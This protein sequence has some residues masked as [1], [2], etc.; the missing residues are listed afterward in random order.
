MA[1][2]K[3]VWNIQ[4]VRDKQL[5]SLWD[6][7]ATDPYNLF[8]W[9]INTEG[10]LGLN[11]PTGTAYSSPV[12]LPGT[13][14]RVFATGQSS[15]G[16]FL[17]GDVGTL[18]SFG[19]NNNGQLGLNDV[20]YRSSP[21]QIPGTTWNKAGG[22]ENVKF[23]G[24]TDGTLWTWGSNTYGSLGINNRTFHSSPVQIPGT[25]WTGDVEVGTSC[26]AIKTDGTL[27]VWGRNWRG[28]LG[29]NNLSKYS[30]PVQLP[31]TWSKLTL[32]QSM[33][34]IKTNGELWAWGRQW[35]G[36]LGQNQGGNNDNY[37]YSSPVQIPGTTW[38]NVGTTGSSMI[39][40]KTNGTLW[41]WGYNTRGQLGQNNTTQYSSPIQVGSDTTWSTTAK[42]IVGSS[43]VVSKTDGTLWMWGNGDRGE[44]GNNDNTQYSSPI[45]VPGTWAEYDSNSWYG[46]TIARTPGG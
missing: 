42:I 8:V 33:A 1:T 23:G 32:G 43:C 16:H 22:G 44:L 12:Q 17:S 41:S 2:Q 13:W 14:R 36:S 28:E 26:G 25:T 45:Q 31:G 19:K 35:G 21:T 34:G 39:A 11:Q 37:S 24:R 27:W 38:A 29:L 6:Y 4:Q 40:V 30:S 15:E 7:T 20:I 10:Q 46:S 5:Q 18:W 3:G 9:G